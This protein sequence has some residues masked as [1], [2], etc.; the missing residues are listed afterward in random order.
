MGD[1]PRDLRW[2]GPVS[3]CLCGSADFVIHGGFDE[4]GDLAWWGL[5]ATCSGCEA[6]VRVPCP[7]D[8][9]FA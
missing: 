1:A 6:L 5:D 3:K 4:F 2:A 9:D 8:K 7:R